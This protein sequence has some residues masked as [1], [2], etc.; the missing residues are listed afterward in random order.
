MKNESPLIIYNQDSTNLFM[1]TQDPI[2][3]SHVDNMV[4]EVANAGVDLMLICPNAQTT[5]Y[6]SEVWQTDWDGYEPGDRTFWGSV[7]EESIPRREHRLRQES[8]LA[9]NGC[10]YLE[11]S[12]ACCR[13][14]GVRPGVTVR[15]NDIHDAPWPDSPQH[16]QFYKNNEKFHLNLPSSLGWSAK[17]LDYTHQEV[18]DHFLRLIEEIA[19]GYDFDVLEL[20]FL[21][22]VDYFPRGD[23]QE[24]RVIINAF[25]KRVREI[26]EKRKRETAL[27]ARIASTPAGAKELGF[28]VKAWAESGLVDGVTAGM[29]LSTGWNIPVDSFRELI[30]EKMKLFVCAEARADTRPTLPSR[31][32]PTS[33]ELIRGFVSGYLAKGVDGIYFFNFFTPRESATGGPQPRFQTINEIKSPKTLIDNPRVHLITSGVT[34]AETDLPTRIP[35]KIARR[36]S[37]EFEMLMAKGSNSDVRM[38]VVY[39]GEPLSKEELWMRFNDTPL[40]HATKVVKGDQSYRKTNNGEYHSEDTLHSVEFT[41]PEESV[42]DGDNSF[43]IRN[44]GREINVLGIEVGIAKRTR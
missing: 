25:I 40:G 5:N 35:V 37:K 32:M 42:N 43:V 13:K 4:K 34:Q 11:R 44:E 2:E 9:E 26:I 7:P 19:D 10:D 1:T 17:G 14:H 28:D 3:P 36:Q 21:R 18:R 24:K 41:I 27:F 20:D 29:F 15:M 39:D 38:I 16:S 23:I 22:F 33:D 12:L 8:R 6:P 31:I 30:G